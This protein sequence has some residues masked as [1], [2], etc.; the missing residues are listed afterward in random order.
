M[1]FSHSILDGRDNNRVQDIHMDEQQLNIWR[2]KIMIQ[3]II[4]LDN[5]NFWGEKLKQEERDIL[6][7]I[8]NKINYEDTIQVKNIE[9]VIDHD[10]A[11]CKKH[12]ENLLKEKGLY[13]IADYV[14]F[15]FT[16]E[17]VSNLAYNLLLVDTWTQVIYPYIMTI[18]N[19]LKE[20]AIKHK[21]DVC[22]SR[23]HGQVAPPTTIGRI[24]SEFVHR[25]I[26]ILEQFDKIIFSGKCS[27]PVGNN[28]AITLLKPDFPYHEYAKSFVEFFGFKYDRVTNQRNSH[29]EIAE[30]FSCIQ[31]LSILCYDICINIKRYT[32]FDILEELVNKNHIGSSVMPHKKNLWK[33]E[34][35]AGIFS[36]LDGILGP[37]YMRIIS[38]NMQR[39]LS[40][41]VYERTYVTYI[42]QLKNGLT[43]LYEGLEVITK[44]SKS[45]QEV[46]EHPEVISEAIQL[47]RRYY[48]LDKDSYDIL[49]TRTRTNNESHLD[50]L[51]KDIPD[52]ETKNRLLNCTIDKYIGDAL[53]QIEYVL[54]ESIPTPTLTYNRTFIVF[55]F[56]ETLAETYELFSECLDTVLQNIDYQKPE[57]YDILKEQYFRSNINFD[58]IFTKLFD[59]NGHKIL[60]LYRELAP[61][62]KITS[63]PYVQELIKYL[64]EKKYHIAIV[65]NRT[66]LMKQRLEEINLEDL[67]I[68]QPK[69]KKPD[70]RAFDELITKYNIRKTEKIYY[71]G[72]HITDY[73]STK[74]NNII[75]YGIIGNSSYDDFIKI[76]VDENNILVNLSELLFYI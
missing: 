13:V 64:K 28:N 29:I 8:Y 21:N 62:I 66:I 55:D 44:G 1:A 75:F 39:D 50:D 52:E 45:L 53:E 69:F 32:E 46:L 67:D 54:N 70:T 30:F 73:Q 27:G 56:D 74:G 19:K 37:M 65:T 17:D 22:V 41:H 26:I 20:L 24:F 16:S 35:G 61:Q 47:A 14:H 40:D 4:N 5:W 42:S 11:A 48:H 2:M 63:K 57:N 12:V 72:D 38:S 23:T 59:S 25:F 31:R 68:Y 76:G 10:V 18:I 49:K 36:M 7:I 43:Y 71:I 33:L 58:D 51:I 15:P 6:S 3:N 34:Y 60:Q 9:K